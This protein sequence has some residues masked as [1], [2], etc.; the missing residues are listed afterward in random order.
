M[1][2]TIHC[3]VLFEQWIVGCNF[4]VSRSC[5]GLVVR[6]LE[7]Y[8]RLFGVDPW[9]QARLFEWGPDL[10]RLQV[11]FWSGTIWG[12]SWRRKWQMLLRQKLI[13]FYKWD[14]E[15]FFIFIATWAGCILQGSFL[16]AAYIVSFIIACETLVSPL[17][18]L[19]HFLVQQGM[20]KRPYCISML[21]VQGGFSVNFKG[22][23]DV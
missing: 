16:M 14:T 5:H 15:T 8:R 2:Y 19:Q 13:L 9:L 7:C 10:V 1:Q 11:R 23:L 22:L 12:A 6:M 4:C 18:C 3:I 21:I 20:Q 17:V